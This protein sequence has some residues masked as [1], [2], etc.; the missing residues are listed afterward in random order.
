M[1]VKNEEE[2]CEKIIEMSRNNNYTTG[3]LLDFAYFKEHYRLIAIDLRKQTNSK[4]LLQ[5]NFIG[6]LEEVIRATVFF[7]IEK[8]KETTSK[9]LQNS[10]NIL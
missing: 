2:A 6:N 3:S 9:F 1:P 5:I 8:L 10:D 7:V 4:D